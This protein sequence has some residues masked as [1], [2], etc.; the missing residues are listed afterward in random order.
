MIAVVL[1]A[2]VIAVGMFILILATYEEKNNG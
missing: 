1:I 2:A